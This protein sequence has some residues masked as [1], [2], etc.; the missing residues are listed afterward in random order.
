MLNPLS[1]KTMKNNNTFLS[2]VWLHYFANCLALALLFIFIISCKKETQINSQPINSQPVEQHDSCF[3][4]TPPMETGWGYEYTFDTIS[5][6]HPCFNPNN[7]NEVA[8]FITDKNGKGLYNCNISTKSKQLIYASEIWGVPSWSI[9]NWLIFNRPGNTIWKIKSNGDSLTQV[10]SSVGY[11]PHWSP[12]ANYYY[13]SN[14][15]YSNKITICETKTDSVIRVLPLNAKCI[16]NNNNV[17]IYNDTHG[18]YFYFFD[19][20]STFFKWFEYGF[21]GFICYWLNNNEA[22]YYYNYKLFKI[23]TQGETTTYGIMPDCSSWHYGLP[24]F[25]PNTNKIIWQKLTFRDDGYNTLFTKC[26]LV[27]TNSDGSLES[28]INIK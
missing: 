24:T 15:A 5:Y 6:E 25:Q 1:S 3:T 23:N 4:L 9:S 17:L 28:K 11:D 8:V 26:Y 14:P 22:I 19:N 18:M 7:S 21:D 13:Y 12:D 2:F 27:M 10:T 16:W 20:D